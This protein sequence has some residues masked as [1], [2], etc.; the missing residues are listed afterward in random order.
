MSII[1]NVKRNQQQTRKHDVCVI[2]CFFIR[3]NG[4]VSGSILTIPF[5]VYIQLRLVPYIGCGRDCIVLTYWG[6]S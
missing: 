3:R 5:N 2:T 6:V 1:F 4:F